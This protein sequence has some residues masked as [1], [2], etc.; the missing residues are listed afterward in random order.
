MPY[1]VTCLIIETLSMVCNE[2][3]LAKLVNNGTLVDEGDVFMDFELPL[4]ALDITEVE[5]QDVERYLTC[6]AYKSVCNSGWY[7]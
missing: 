2:L 4:L 5:L 1:G 3:S 7:C 6:G